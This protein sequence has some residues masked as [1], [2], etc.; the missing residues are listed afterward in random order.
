MWRALC[1]TGIT[2][3][4]SLAQQSRFASILGSQVDGVTT[5]EV[6]IKRVL[7]SVFDKSGLV[8]ICKFL[9][10]PSVNAE[11]ISTG[12]T[13]SLLRENG[14][15]VKEVSEITGSPEI[16][17][18]RVKSL[19]PTV[20][21]GILAVRSHSDHMQDL[22]DNG[23]PEIDMVIGNLYPFEEA[24]QTSGGDYWTAAENVDIGGPTMIRG[25]A[26]N[27]GSV[28]VVT[29][30]DQYSALREELKRH[31]QSGSTSLEFRKRLAREAFQL[32]AT[33]ESAIAN[34]FSATAESSDDSAV[35]TNKITLKYGNN[36]HQN[37]AYVQG[38][39]G[40][41]LPFN[42]LNGTPGYINLLDALNAWQLVSEAR[43]ALGK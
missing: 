40:K 4:V 15:D 17:G 16:L 43:T 23:I 19:H 30:P 29:S 26:K 5:D 6:P 39:D 25:A 14:I 18:G 32:T 22:A 2:R 37:P 12:G 1:R 38:I 9:A 28:A 42:I 41:P 7:V 11:I 36:P 34:F 20:H 27:H 10:S 8:D 31:D 3:R 13:A 35:D 33:Y 21:G 24:V